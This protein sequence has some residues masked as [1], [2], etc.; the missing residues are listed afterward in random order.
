MLG[1]YSSLADM[2]VISAADAINE[3]RLKEV[4]DKLKAESKLRENAMLGLFPFQKKMFARA[5]LAEF[6]KEVRRE[7]DN[8]FKA[9]I[10]GEVKMTKPVFTIEH[11]LMA[12]HPYRIYS[13]HCGTER[14]LEQFDSLRK[15]KKYLKVLVRGGYDMHGKKIIK[16]ASNE[17]DL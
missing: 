7:I 3:Q 14:P 6:E 13:E 11:D 17:G 15:A 10:T 8:K 5:T 16:Y 2:L 4:A 12:V 9:A 1:L